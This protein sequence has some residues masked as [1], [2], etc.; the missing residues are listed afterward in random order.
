MNTAGEDIETAKHK[1]IAMECIIEFN[2]IVIM[3]KKKKKVMKS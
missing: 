2:L 1:R 3:K